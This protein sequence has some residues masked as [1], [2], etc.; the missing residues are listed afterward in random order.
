MP[1]NLKLNDKLID[2]VLQLGGFKNRQQAVNAALREYV[3]RRQRLSILDL[4][5]QI[6]FDPRWDYK[7]MRRMRKGRCL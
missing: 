7:K 1:V 3:Q 4:E 5:R 6:D 2:R